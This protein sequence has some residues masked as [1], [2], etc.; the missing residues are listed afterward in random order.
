[1]NIE[2]SGNRSNSFFE[3]VNERVIAENCK[4]IFGADV[5]H[6]GEPIIPDRE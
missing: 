1:M 4:N 2:I 5:E 6:N 3:A